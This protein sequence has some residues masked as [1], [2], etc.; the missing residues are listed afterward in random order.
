MY[1][2]AP[3]RRTRRRDAGPVS[4]VILF[5]YFWRPQPTQF[6]EKEDHDTQQ[7]EHQ[8]PEGW[9]TVF[10]AQLRHVPGRDACI[11]VHSINT[12]HKGK[13][14]KDGGDNSEDLHYFV[15]AVAQG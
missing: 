3:V 9:I 13:R 4:K 12:R 14:N 8:G 7:K 15:H 2:E 5:P 10:P 1:P 6:S 11:E